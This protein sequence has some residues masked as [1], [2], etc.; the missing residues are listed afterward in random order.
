[1]GAPRRD[2]CVRVGADGRRAGG[3]AKRPNAGL[4]GW[5]EDGALV[6]RLCRRPP[7]S[8][9]VPLGVGWR[10]LLG[11]GRECRGKLEL[12]MAFAAKGSLQC[13]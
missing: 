12:K 8:V 1:M 10:Q 2:V 4:W 3:A 9:A 5:E 13:E 11:R 7:H 6:G